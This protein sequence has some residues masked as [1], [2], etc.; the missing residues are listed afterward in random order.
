MSNAGISLADNILVIDRGFQSIYN[1]Q[2]QINL[3]LKYIQFLSLTE[4]AVKQRLRRRAANL[5]DSL[6]NRDP[7][8]GLTAVTD[9]EPWTQTIPGIGTLAIN[10]YLH[11]YRNPHLATK[12]TDELHRKVLELEDQKNDVDN[13]KSAYIDPEV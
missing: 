13:P 9:R 6:A 12:Q 8:L 4:D 10:T 5:A 7:R 11:L 3:E 1:T 2:T